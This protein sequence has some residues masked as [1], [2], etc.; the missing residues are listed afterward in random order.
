MRQLAADAAVRQGVGRARTATAGSS[1]SARTRPSSASSTTSTTCAAPLAEL[2]VGYPVVIDNDFAIWR[3]VREPLLAGR[4]PRRRRGARP[5]PALR[6][7]GLRGDRA[8]DPA[9]AGRRRGARARRRRRARR[10]GRLGHAAV[11]R[12]LRGLRP[13]RAPQPTR[14]ADGLALNQ[15]ALTGEWS[16]GEEAAVLDAA[17]G[18]IAYRFEAPRPQPGPRAAGSGGA[19]PLRGAPRR[20]AARRRPRPRRRRVRRGRGRRAAACTSSSASAD[21]VRERTFEITFLDPGVRAYVFTF[22]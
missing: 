14:R 15:W 11:P 1:S 19:G 9:A 5:L 4:L 12:D 8:S 22:G 20:R 7:G 21:A 6:R 2:G 3:V 16:V 13:R 17:G 10:G 18:S